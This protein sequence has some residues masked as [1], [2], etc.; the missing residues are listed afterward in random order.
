MA[1]DSRDLPSRP[2]RQDVDTFLRKVA[3]APPQLQAGPGGRLLFAMDA[4]ASRAALWDRASHIQAEMFQETAQLGTLHVQLAYYRGY[5][6]FR[7]GPWHEGSGPLLREMTAVTCLSGL[8]QIAKVLRHCLEQTRLQ[9][10]QALVFIGDCCEEDPAILAELAGQ[11]GLRGVPA[12]IFQEGHQPDAERVFRKIAALT[13]GAWCHF[14]ASS[15]QQLR[16]LLTAVAVYA[17]GGRNALQMW[18]RS[19]G[20]ATQKLLQQ[21][22]GSLDN[23]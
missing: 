13:G 12:F 3:A 17:V 2:Q 23:P 10:V 19:S 18:P 1:K 21:L 15:A 7:A 11:L 9:K 6:E 5:G 22:R 20:S 14:D 16:E 8:T 4:T